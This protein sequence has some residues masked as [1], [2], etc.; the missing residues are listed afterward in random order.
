[1]IKR[2]RF[3]RIP[4]D[5]P[6]RRIYYRLGFADGKTA[7]AAEQQRQ[8]DECICRA[9]ALVQVQAV[10]ARAAFELQTDEQVGLEDG[11]V[12]RSRS[13]ADLLRGAVEILIMAA[14]A[15]AEIMARIRQLQAEG[16]M[17][18]AV[19]YDATASELSD[20]ALD[21]LMDYVRR[22]VVRENKSVTARRF[23]AGYGDFPLEN[24][25]LIFKLLALTELGVR[26]NAQ[27]IMEPEKSVSAVAG[28]VQRQ[29]L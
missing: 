15:G 2:Q 22:A 16:R 17:Q 1:M 21:W 18:E 12:F 14:T 3:E 6:W 26:L 19:I 28:I 23:S 13:V 10:Y 27:H 25:G 24:Q 29:E 11:T 9:S 5:I 4:L 20:A 7:L 8:I